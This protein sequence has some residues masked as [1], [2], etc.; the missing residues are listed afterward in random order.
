[1]RIPPERTDSMPT[2]EEKFSALKG[3]LRSMKRVG[4]AFSGGVDSTLLLSAAHEALG[5]NAIA[6]T[7][8]LRSVP[9]FERREAAEFCAANGIKQITC[10]IDELKL[11]EF[12]QNPSDRCYH[13]KCAVMDTLIEEASKNKILCIVEGSN[14]DD[15]ADF[16]PGRRALKE[17]GIVSPLLDA[18][19][20]KAEIRELSRR[21]NL[22]T[23]DKP[24]YA[25][26]ASRIPCGETITEEKLRMIEKAENF[27]ISKGIRAMRVR[28]HG[29]LARIETA[30]EDIERLAEPEFRRELTE[31]LKEFGFRYVA[32]D[33]SGYKT[34][35]MNPERE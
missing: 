25:C 13:C 11:P 34:G 32:L 10:E 5:E 27:L 1:M 24:A 28:A 14:T 20:S 33:L 31:K 18:G 22:P 29:D 12:A 8:A 17:K 19:L 21:L 35:N 4:V 26:L 15:L 6:L 2:L 16:R 3:S 23:W 30:S 7:A 9:E